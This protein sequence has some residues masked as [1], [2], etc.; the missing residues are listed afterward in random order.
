LA[1][2]LSRVVLDWPGWREAGPEDIDFEALTRYFKLL[3]MAVEAGKVSAPLRER[4]RLAAA[5]LE[6]DGSPGWFD[7]MGRLIESMIALQPAPPYRDG[8]WA[9]RALDILLSDI[10]EEQ[11]RNSR[12]ILLGEVERVY[13]CAGHVPPQW[14]N[15]LRDEIA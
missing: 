10:P 14:V 8:T 13:T 12:V 11:V 9:L 2:T 1:H 5:R 7:R 6:P 3:R 15:V 4:V